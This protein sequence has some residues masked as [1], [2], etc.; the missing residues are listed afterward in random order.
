MKEIGPFLVHKAF[1]TKNEY[2]FMRIQILP[3][4]IGFLFTFGYWASA[5]NTNVVI[6]SPGV[7]PDN[8]FAAFQDVFEKFQLVFTFNPQDR[9]KLHL[10]FA[11]KRLSELNES[12]TQN[13]TDLIP[14]LTQKFEKEMNE[15][16][17]EIN[18][19]KDSGQN[20]TELA[21][22]VA[23]VTFKHQLVLEDVSGKVS[24][25]AKDNIE[26]AINVSSH[27]H[28]TAVE[29]IL[30][31]ENITGLVNI[32]FNVGNQS[33]TQTFNVTI[34]DNNTHVEKES[35]HNQSC[36]D[37]CNETIRINPAGHQEGS[38]N[39]ENGHGGENETNSSST[40]NTITITTTHGKSGEEGNKNNS[41]NSSENE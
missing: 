8:V 31:H 28:N 3:V 29:N 30:E 9:A 39:E 33:F 40:N 41:G 25:Q 5:Q 27:G 38:H 18:A 20:V 13:K 26:H 10:Q 35:E 23:E 36:E 12:I 34:K 32:T 24:E 14:D 21:E 6:A 17:R 15:T 37:H 4:L 11:E 2:N 22:H 16:E 19:T 1:K 7:L